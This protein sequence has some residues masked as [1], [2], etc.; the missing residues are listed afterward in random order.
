MCTQGGMC[1]N[2]SQTYN[3]H[4]TWYTL[5]TE[6][7]GCHYPTSSLPQYYGAMNTA[8]YLAGAVCGACVE[9]TNSQNGRKLEVVIADEC[10]E[11]SN[12][13]WCFT[14]S[15][16]IDLIQ[17]AYNALGANNNPAITWKYIPCSPQGGIKYFF[18]KAA[19]QGYLAVTPMNHRHRIS[20]ME[21]QSPAGMWIEL[22]RSYYDMWESTAQLG[23][24]PYNFRVTDIHGHMI[25]DNGIEMKPA[26][27]VNGVGQFNACQ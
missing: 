12:K 24:G 11:E 1:M 10:P 5:A 26:M 7:V 16:H 15:H 3:G 22:K 23:P 20:K 18:D 6:M 14:G 13:Q 4:I 19:K 21:V 27:V 8:D 25:Q 9:I 17:P 2:D